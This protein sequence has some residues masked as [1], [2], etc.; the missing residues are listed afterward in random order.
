MI[1]R[2]TAIVTMLGASFVGTALCG[3]STPSGSS[4]R[5]NIA[6]PTDVPNKTLVPGNYTIRIVD[7]LRD[8][9]IIR[10]ARQGTDEATFLALPVS[11][12]PK[13]GKPGPITLAGSDGRQALRGFSFPDGT[14]AEFVFPKSDA[15]AIAK[16]NNTTVPAIDPASEGRVASADLPAAD[17]QMV[18]LWMLTP[19]KV[20]PNDASPSIKAARYKQAGLVASLQ[21]PKPKAVVAVLPHTAGFSPMVLLAAALALLGGLFLTSRRLVATSRG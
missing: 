16:M 8:R 17:L 10:V 6:T 20:G 1:R 19:T 7:H 11:G 21:M 12:L 3:Q 9:M 18:T 15:V 5:F 4:T 13:T 14:L 2:I